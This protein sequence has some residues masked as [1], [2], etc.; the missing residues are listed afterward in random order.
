MRLTSYLG[1]YTCRP[2]PR[3][4]RQP[5]ARHIEFQHRCGGI[6]DPLPVRLVQCEIVGRR[7]RNTGRPDLVCRRGFAL[8]RANARW[9]D[10]PFRFRERFPSRR[11]DRAGT[12]RLARRYRAPDRGARDLLSWRAHTS[13][14]NSRTSLPVTGRW[15]PPIGSPGFPPRRS[16]SAEA[17]STFTTSRTTRPTTSPGRNSTSTGAWATRV[18]PTWQAGLNGYFYQ[19]TTD[20]T[21][22]GADV[23]GGNRGRAAAIG[24]FIRY[25]PSK[26]F[27]IALKWQKEFAVENRASGNRFFCGFPRSC[28]ETSWPCAP[29]AGSEMRR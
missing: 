5:P 19:Q 7:D 24:P 23:P 16:K 8:R 13:R 28:G 10:S 14:L 2:D 4:L 29:R 15:R 6:H 17:L 20:D 12:A 27:G 25:H 18:T 26:D 21:L 22:N 9:Q 11:S 3:R 1:Y